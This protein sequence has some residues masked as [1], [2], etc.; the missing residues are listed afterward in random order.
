[1]RNHSIAHPLCGLFSLLC[2]LK[3]IGL[4]QERQSPP[5]E[6]AIMLFDGL[7]FSRWTDCD[8]GEVP[9]KIVNGV[10]EIIPDLSNKC[11]K[12]QGIKT[13][14]TFRDFYLHVEFR[15]PDS[16]NTNSGVYLL[17]R[18][19]IQI[20]YSHQEPFSPGMGGSLY[21][22]KMPDVNVGRP[23][24]EWESYDIIFRSPRFEIHDDFFRKTED[25]RLTVTQNGV[26]THNNVIVQSQTGVGFPETP[27]PGP[28][29]LQDH[30]AR[31]QFRNIWIYP[32]ESPW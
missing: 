17:K 29:M 12:I 14:Q 16:D 7:D 6:G 11:E 20:N 3:P 1:M 22:Q 8:G 31:V 23:K 4:A 5:P 10:M 18:Y 21:R 26:V 13:K 32:S 19:E 28:I 25:A 15:L 30:G 9:W 27:E 2:L 24:G